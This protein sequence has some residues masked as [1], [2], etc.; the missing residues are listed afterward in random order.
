MAQKPM[1]TET[2][3]N[4]KFIL[5][6][7]NRFGLD[8]KWGNPTEKGYE[9]PVRKSK[10]NCEPIGV[11]EDS[12]EKGKGKG[13]THGR[14]QESSGWQVIILHI[15][16]SSIHHFQFIHFLF[17]RWRFFDGNGG[18]KEVGR[19]QFIPCTRNH[20]YVQEPTTAAERKAPTPSREQPPSNSTTSSRHIL[21]A[22]SSPPPLLLLR[23]CKGAEGNR[24]GDGVFC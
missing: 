2:K 3:F 14:N 16:T 10:K 1:Q 7:N 22:A 20:Q 9:N 12:G 15:H 11:G 13:I 17:D 8:Q 5:K 6:T 24:R 19:G 18:R 4:R 23:I 21:T